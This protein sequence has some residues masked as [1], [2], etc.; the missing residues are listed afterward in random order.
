MFINL[1]S[2]TDVVQINTA[3]ARI[4]FVK[5]PIIADSQSKF[6]PALESLVRE[7]S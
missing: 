5:N 1:S 4:E 6:G 7:V 2:V 3:D